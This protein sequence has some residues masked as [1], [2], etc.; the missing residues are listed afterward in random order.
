MEWQHWQKMANLVFELDKKF[1][2]REP[3]PA[4]QRIYDRMVATMEEAG[5]HLHNPIG[6]AYTETSTD[7]EASISGSLAD[8]LRVTEVIKPVLYADVDGSRA[9]LQKGVV[10]VEGTKQAIK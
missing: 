7:V 10:I 4:L 8:H 2:S 1:L 9:L 3:N 6:T 5:I